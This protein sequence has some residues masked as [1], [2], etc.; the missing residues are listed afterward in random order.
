MVHKVFQ[1]TQTIELLPKKK[2]IPVTLTVPSMFPPITHFEVHCNVKTLNERLRG[3]DKPQSRGS[4]FV[5]MK[6][7]ICLHV[8]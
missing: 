3:K 5:H 6:S 7:T 4:A 2:K 8:F 1:G